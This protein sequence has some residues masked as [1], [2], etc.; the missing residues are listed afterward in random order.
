[1]YSKV[2]KF[3]CYEDSHLMKLCMLGRSWPTPSEEG[4]LGS[5]KARPN[6]N[7]IRTMPQCELKKSIFFPKSLKYFCSI[8]S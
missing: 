8:S 6:M 7:L 1:M 2:F 3:Q 4:K 5:G